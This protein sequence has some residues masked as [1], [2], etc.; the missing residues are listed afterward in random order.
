MIKKEGLISKI[1]GAVILIGIIV[2]VVVMKNRGGVINTVTTVYS[3]T[4]GGKEDLLA[5]EEIKKIF[6]NNYKIELENDVWSNGKT[7]REDVVRSDGSKYDLIFFS[8]QRFHDYYKTPTKEGE[9]QRYTV[10]KSD[11]TLNTPIVI[12]SWKNVVSVLEKEKIVTKE[13]GVYYITDMNK[14]IDYI[15][16]GKKWSELGSDVYGTINIG[17]VDPVTSSPGATYYGL[18]LSILTNGDI[19]DE[20]V[21][22]ALPK[23]KTF[24]QKSGYMNNAPADLFS[25]FLKTGEYAKPLIV[26]YEKSIIDFANTNPEGWEAVKDK[27]V[28]LYPTPTIWNSHYIAALSENGETVI[29]AFN[30]KK[31]RKIAWEKY[32]FR[33]G[34]SGGVNDVSSLPINGIP[35]EITKVTPGLKMEYYNQLIEYLK[36]N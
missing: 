21:A 32:G 34:Y 22:Q 3:A 14:L 6:A 28:V 29:K 30:D 11:A 16:E 36:E 5:D 23:L 17:S 7:I 2:I 4:G 18:L 25:M 13:N 15:L 27:V 10:L 33:V 24:Y 9:A 26:D 12:Y 35:S 1:I 31:V 20:S 8:D 19:N